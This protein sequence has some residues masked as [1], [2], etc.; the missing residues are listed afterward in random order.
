MMYCTH[1]AF[2]LSLDV[3]TP[4]DRQ[5]SS[6]T[7]LMDTTAPDSSVYEQRDLFAE[8]VQLAHT[9]PELHSRDC[10]AL[11]Y[12]SSSDTTAYSPNSC[13]S[14]G[15][16][17]T[18]ESTVTDASLNQSKASTVTVVSVSDMSPVKALR[19]NKKQQQQKPVESPELSSDGHYSTPQLVFSP[20]S[21]VKRIPRP[22]VLSPRLPT[23]STASSSASAPTSA[24]FS[25]T[26]PHQP[27]WTNDKVNR[28]DLAADLDK[29][30]PVPPMR[31]KSSPLLQQRY[32]FTAARSLKLKSEDTL[33]PLP[34]TASK[35]PSKKAIR[36][37]RSTPL[38]R[39]SSLLPT[40]QPPM[41]SE[42]ILEL[43]MQQRKSSLPTP[44]LPM[45]SAPTPLA[46][47]GMPI[48]APRKSSLPAIFS[49]F[50]STSE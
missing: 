2:D 23:S 28:D 6:S 24:S 45:R 11:T 36:A 13:S 12:C 21:P 35:T 34:E 19:I 33:N 20:G 32:Q 25:P 10:T 39:P 7:V 42:N 15:F 26:T 38:F 5:T 4:R 22:L 18:R 17:H 29:S 30:L 43:A 37:A 27:V 49:R 48:L 47:L 1:R 50:P 46:P 8:I 44:I 31:M 3:R 14:F 16:S 40:R 41:P 9:P